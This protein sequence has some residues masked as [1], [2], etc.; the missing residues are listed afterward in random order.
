ME[1]RFRVLDS[2]KI[3]HVGILRTFVPA[4][5]CRITNF[6]AKSHLLENCST[7]AER[8]R[9][10][11][12]LTKARL[13]GHGRTACIGM[14]T[15]DGGTHPDRRFLLH[16]RWNETVGTGSGSLDGANYGESHIPFPHFNAVFVSV[17]EFIGS[18]CLALGLLTR[19]CAL[20]LVCVMVV[21]IATNRIQSIQSSGVLP[22]LD[23]FLYLPEVLYV[24]ILAWLIFSGSGRYSID[25]WL[26]SASRREKAK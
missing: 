26:L 25:G 5:G 6:D 13:P 2:M 21:A 16:L 15:D 22:W 14:D 12:R 7:N 8:Q 19:A 9:H 18:G 20:M 17:V 24:I 10:E 11:Y 23:D 4:R 3:I 1:N